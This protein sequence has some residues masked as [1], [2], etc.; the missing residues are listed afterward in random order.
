M[1]PSLR[2]LCSATFIV[3]LM[4]L[5]SACDSND[6]D[7]DGAGEQEVISNVILSFE[8]TDTGTTQEFEAVFDEAGELVAADP[9]VL[10]TDQ[11]FEVSVAL[12]NRFASDPDEADITEEVRD[13][14][15]EEHRFFYE[16][17]PGALLLL[18][19][20]SEDPNGDPLGLTFT[21]A[22]PVGTGT[23][24]FRVKLRHYEEDANLPE[25]KIDDTIDAAEVAGVVETDVDILFDLVII[26]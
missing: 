13:E 2:M 10:A 24:T 3:A 26:E 12:R 11:T 18:S 14:E 8:N 21:A 16:A 7:D 15:P 6:P 20:L 17:N 22:T 9:V 1:M 19:D 25:D 23:G 4:V 5:V